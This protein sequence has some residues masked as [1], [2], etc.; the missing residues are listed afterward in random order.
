MSKKHPIIWDADP[1]TIA[2]IAILKNYLSAWF[3][4]VGSRFSGPLVYIDGFAGP[5]YYKNNQEGSPL[6]ALRIFQSYLAKND[7][8]LKI[9]SVYAVF[10]E[11][12]KKRF[13]V[14]AEQTAPFESNGA[15]KLQ[16][17]NLPFATAMRE[18]MNEPEMAPAFK[19][20]QPLFVFA[21]PYGGTG[22]LFSIF[23]EFLQSSGSELLLNFDADGIARIHAG[24]NPNWETQLDEVYGGRCWEETLEVP[25]IS[26]ARKAERALELYQRQLLKIAGVDFVWSFEM[27][28][29]N[30]KINYYLVFATRNRLGM[31]KM[32][33]AMRQLDKTGGYR[34]SDAHVGQDMLFREDSIDVF[35]NRLHAHFIG[36]DVSYGDV[37]RFALCDSP[38][39]NPKSMLIF[40]SRAG[41]V[42]AF[43]KAG[44]NLRKHSFPE[45]SVQ[46]VSFV[47][48]PT[49]QFQNDLFS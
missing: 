2:K 36:K 38:F 17:L 33:E 1:H 37:D 32:K 43:P 46:Y 3:P 49:I 28:G 18:I 39:T 42:V 15:V 45:E 35:A 9:R 40:L 30:D 41:R 25:G 13:E 31:E 10:I 4:I 34:F 44:C 6:A 26:L 48:A 24:Q 21:D 29:K 12:D 19:G 8:P 5:G 11:A 27:R 16:R 23:E 14:L 47:Q 20:G 22:I 7:P